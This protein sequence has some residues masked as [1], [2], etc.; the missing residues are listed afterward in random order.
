MVAVGVHRRRRHRVDGV[1][2]NQLVDVENVAIS[3]VLGP[4]ARPQEPLRLGAL[5]R[6][7]LPAL[8]RV[9]VFVELIGELRVGD[10]NFALQ[11]LQLGLCGRRGSCGDLLV[12]LVVHQG[13]DAAHEEARH[14]GHLVRVP[15][16][17]GKSFQPGNVGVGDFRIDLLR[18][19]Q[20]DVDVDPLADQG[21]DR[22]QPRLGAGHLDHQVAPIHL[23][24]QPARFLDRLMRVHRQIGRDFE[25]DEAVAP[26]RLLVD[27][28][29]RVGALLDVADREIL[30]QRAGIEISR[31]LRL[32]DQ[33][34]VIIAVADR[35]LENRGVRSDAAQPVL[36]DQLGEA[37]ALQQIAADKVEPYRLPELVKRP[38]RIGHHPTP[39]ARAAAWQPHRGFRR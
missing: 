7:P 32:G 29:Q 15:A 31:G 36:A 8:V 19:Q 24:P 35:L 4:G 17:F 6:Q 33:S 3:L 1:G 34:V 27:A 20:S 12:E 11:L 30:E 10:R 5:L 37:P 38:Q 18:K 21:A 23:V 39:C 14:A 25:A 2:A 16:L 22:R 9:D 13:I 28:V 26:L